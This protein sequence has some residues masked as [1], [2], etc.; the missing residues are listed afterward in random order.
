M[1]HFSVMCEGQ[2]KFEDIS[3]I[4]D[5]IRTSATKRLAT[6][7][8]SRLALESWLRVNYKAFFEEAAAAN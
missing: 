6:Y 5:G 4:T 2:V 1:P 7:L 8:V 3:H